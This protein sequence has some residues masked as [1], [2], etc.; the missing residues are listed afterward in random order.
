MELARNRTGGGGDLKGL[1]ATRRGTL[2][3]A[4]AC[5]VAAAAILV[6]AINQYRSSVNSAST[7]DT[8]LVANGLIQK[9][10]SGAEITSGQL[11]TPT[12]L[13][14]KS[15]TTGAIADAA[16]LQGKVAAADILPGQQ[17]TA[18]D[19]TLG[20]GVANQLAANQRAISVPLDSS[21]GL[22]GVLASGERVD[23]YVGF[24]VA[25][26]NGVSGPVLR[27]LVPNVLVLESNSAGN[28][29]ANGGNVVLAVNANQAA[30]VAYASDN[31]KIW[32]LLR[33]GNAQNPATTTATLQSILLG[34]PQI[35]SGGKP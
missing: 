33:P 3:V 31:G 15:V 5:A 8:V 24:N 4:L 32:L 28:N 16:V 18:A 10:T 35:S 2:I 26:Q 6:F 25:G 17:L 9:G 34:Q 23:L 7:Q 29:N 22:S 21:H 12:K 27:L 30:A 1:L 20:T 13:T 11:F 19:F 14:S